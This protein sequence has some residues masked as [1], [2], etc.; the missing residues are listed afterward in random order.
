[1]YDD[2]HANS[3]KLVMIMLNEP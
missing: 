2:E 3:S 1:M